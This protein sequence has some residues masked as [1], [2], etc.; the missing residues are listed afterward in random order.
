MFNIKP[1]EN[2][3]LPCPFCGVYP[4]LYCDLT[5]WKNQPVYKPNENG[6]R[7]IAYVIRAE[8]NK[9]CFIRRMNGMNEDGRMDAF[10]WECLVDAW[11]RRANDD[12]V[13]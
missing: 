5:D 13:V 12:P 4:R 9:N 6:Y 11:N 2:T 10:N 7:P 3:L 1:E 8:H